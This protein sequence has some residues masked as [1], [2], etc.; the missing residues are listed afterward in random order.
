MTDLK[1]IGK[2]RSTTTKKQNKKLGIYKIAAINSTSYCEAV[3]IAESITDAIDTP[4]FAGCPV[5]KIA[6]ILIGDAPLGVTDKIV[7]LS[8]RHGCMAAVA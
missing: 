1:N 2:G 7:V 6:A 5:D 8:K 3:I 4:L